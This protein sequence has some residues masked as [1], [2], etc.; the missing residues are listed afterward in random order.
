[1]R[2]TE[3]KEALMDKF[4]EFANDEVHNMLDR[5]SNRMDQLLDEAHSKQ[6]FMLLSPAFVDEY[7]P[8]IVEMA[9]EEKLTA[10]QLDQFFGMAMID[11]EE[12]I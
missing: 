3:E 8:D 7:A 4:N 6:H 9:L 11:M 12:K 10:A 1:M 2:S 5:M